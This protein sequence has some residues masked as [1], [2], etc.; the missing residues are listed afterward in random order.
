MN[1]PESIVNGG[2][3][4]GHW[5]AKQKVIDAGGKSKTSGD[6]KEGKKS[7]VFDLLKS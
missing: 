3:G 5:E 1:M 2:A 4:K 7:N 6:Y